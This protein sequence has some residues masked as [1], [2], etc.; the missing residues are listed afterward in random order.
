M[1]IL[2]KVYLVYLCENNYQLLKKG[3]ELA[4][5]FTEFRGQCRPRHF[6]KDTKAF[7]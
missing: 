3:T 2:F 1:S 7:R 5:S 6:I 4:K